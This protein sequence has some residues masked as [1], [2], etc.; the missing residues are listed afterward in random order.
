MKFHFV[1]DWQVESNVPNVA[2]KPFLR[3]WDTSK[4]L[5]EMFLWYLLHRYANKLYVISSYRFQL[6][7]GEEV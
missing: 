5:L 1:N 6:D 7:C 3:T 2:Q 4:A